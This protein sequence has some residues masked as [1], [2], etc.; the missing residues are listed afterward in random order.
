[1]KDFLLTWILFEIIGLNLS[2]TSILLN[3]IS[4]YPYQNRRKTLQI[5]FILS[6]LKRNVG[7]TN[8]KIRD[9]KNLSSSLHFLRN[10]YH[11]ANYSKIW[12]VS[13]LEQ[14]GFL[15]NLLLNERNLMDFIP[16]GKPKFGGNK[17]KILFGNGGRMES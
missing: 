11:A 17:T 3:H 8:I 4:P 16:F 7:K 10:Q 9:L 15:G 5:Q 1:M 12:W 13:I 6:C 14:I 2:L